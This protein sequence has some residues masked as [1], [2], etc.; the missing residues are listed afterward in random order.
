M[1][2]EVLEYKKE[3][4]ETYLPILT[5]IVE[6]QKDDG[7]KAF[8]RDM[9]DFYDFYLAGMDETTCDNCPRI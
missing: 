4:A 2:Q 6:S 5:K 8:F 7:L 1:E 9:C 3:I